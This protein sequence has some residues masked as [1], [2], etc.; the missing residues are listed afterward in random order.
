MK[1]K[2]Q[3]TIW[4]TAVCLLVAA[5]AIAQAPAAKKKILV[6]GLPDSAVAQLRQAAPAGVQIVSPAMN[7]VGAEI[8]DS[9][10]LICPHLTP[11]ILQAGPKLAWVQI[12]NAGA[13]D[14]IPLVRGKNITLT[15]LKVVL[16]PEVADHAIAL[17]LALTRG[18][19]QTIPT[20]E[21]KVPAGVNQM[22]ELDGK[23]AVVI[24]VGGVG[25]AIA[26]RANAFGMNVIGV[27]PKDAPPP[28]FIKQMVKPNQL[29]SV[30]PQANVVFITVPE[31]PQTK[32]MIG[33]A[34]FKE[35]KRGAYLI[36]VSR[37]TIYSTDALVDAL[38]SGKLAGAGLDV[39][40]P[41]PLPPTSPLWKFQNV[42]ITPHIAGASDS[43][44]PR[45][46]EM[47]QE[48]I[49]HFA[50]GEPLVNV[51]DTTKGY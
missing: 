8:A 2:I 6:V 42:L 39:T 3:G 13:E 48:N 15:N 49:K 21:W 45:V 16:G 44:L 5:V 25:T 29:D 9:D 12:L 18:L 20:R 10:A 22:T 11:Q 46:I 19:Y 33:A 35:M 34:Q 37:G 41:E 31:T 30:L 47:L 40:D 24:G 7:Q 32:G 1:A 4:A 27:D 26:Q 28:A 51:V 17:L 50:A 38:S 23:T 14:A 43:S 36:A